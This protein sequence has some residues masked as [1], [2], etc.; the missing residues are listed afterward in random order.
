MPRVLLSWLCDKD[1]KEEAKIDKNVASARLNMATGE[2][3]TEGY[4]S[5][6]QGY[7]GSQEEKIDDNLQN[8]YTRLALMMFNQT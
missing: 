3:V 4:R 6:I 1:M 7:S 8:S 5:I 2:Q